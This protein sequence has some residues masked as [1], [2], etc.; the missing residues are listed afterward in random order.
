M[1]VLSGGLENVPGYTYSAVR[2]GIRYP[3]RLDYALIAADSDCNAAGV[4][5]KNR[6]TAAP[7]KWSRKNIGNPVRA[8]LVNA[9][10][11]NACTGDPGYENTELLTADIA[12]RLGVPSSAVLM[13]STGIIGHQLP[14]EKML[15][16]HAALTDSLSPDMGPLVPEA[17]MTT[18]T[19]QK[20]ICVSFD[21]GM[22]EFRIAGTAKGAGMIAPDMAT[23]LSFIVTDAPLRRDDLDSL[24]RKS[25]RRSFNAITIDGDMSTNDTAIILCPSRENPLQEESDIAA[26][27]EALDH[28]LM[29]LAEM[30]VLDAEGATRMVKV[31]VKGARSNEDAASIARSIAESLLV[32]TAIFGN[33]PNWGRVACAAGYSG[34]DIDESLLSVYYGDIPLLLNGKPQPYENSSLSSVLSQQIYT[35]TLDAGIGSGT[36]MIMTSDISHEYVRINAEY[37][38]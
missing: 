19:V 2:C 34:A 24:F 9:T 25:V 15:G 11:A 38:T 27:T 37:S 14:V 1:K 28:V 35:I 20:K 31:M 33:D 13:A 12:K 3:D 29:R 16:S 23:L 22:G 10:N 30:L 32:K 5:T 21:T 4:F 17:I 36:W 18:D 26:F 6:V 7:V 8:I